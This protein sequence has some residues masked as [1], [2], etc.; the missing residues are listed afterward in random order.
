MFRVSDS[1]HQFFLK[2]AWGFASGRHF[3][4]HGQVDLSIEPDLL[5]LRQFRSSGKREADDITGREDVAPDGTARSEGGGGASGAGRFTAHPSTEHHAQT[6][7]REPAPP[8][9]S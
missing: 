4:D 8:D 7:Q 6:Q 3:P 9:R 5:G 1:L 2:N